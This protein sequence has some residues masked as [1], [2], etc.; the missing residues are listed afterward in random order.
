MKIIGSLLFFL[1]TFSCFAADDAN[2][3]VH[4]HKLENGLKII[5]KEDHGAPVV[6][7]QLWYKVGSGFEPGGITGISH[8]LEHMMFKGTQKYPAGVFSKIIAENG[9]EENAFTSYDF[10]TYYQK[11]AAKRLEISFKLEADRMQHLNFSPEEFDKEIKVVKEERRMRTDDN[12]SALTYERFYAAANLSNPYHHP[13]IGWMNDLNQLRTSDLAVWYDTWYVPN[14]ATL[15]VVGDVNPDDIFL[16]AKKYFGEIPYHN[17]SPIKSQ[18]EPKPHGTRHIIVEKPAKLPLLLMGFN[19]PSLK[20]VDAPWEAYAL[21]VLAGI[22]DGGSSARLTRELIRGK[23]IAASASAGYDLYRRFD[24]LFILDGIP[25]KGHSVEELKAAFLGQINQLKT[26]LV[27]KDELRRV[28]AQVVANK[29]YERDSLFG[30]ALLIGALESIDLSWR[31]GEEYVAHIKAVTP[32]QI[33][34]VAKKYLIPQRL[35]IAE[36]KPLPLHST[37]VPTNT[38]DKKYVR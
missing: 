1:I 37:T 27:T 11:L 17:L 15:V 35:T 10:T 32:E 16:L 6:V 9:G 33:R 23:Q 12:P 14:N 20:T 28:K 30:Q 3:L 21:D 13:T 4:E 38:K 7:S 26:D 25:S 31:A 19:V 8:V 36:L 34:L 24:S 29:I 18:R 5:V 22:L 2:L